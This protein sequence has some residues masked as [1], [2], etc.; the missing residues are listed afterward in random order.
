MLEDRQSA[1]SRG[2]E[3][4]PLHAHEGEEVAEKSALAGLTVG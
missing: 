4:A 2:E 3:V 1:S